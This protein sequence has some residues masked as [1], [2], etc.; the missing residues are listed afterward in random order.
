MQVAES[1]ANP[2]A[3]PRGIRCKVCDHES[4]TAINSLLATATLSNR[5]TATQFGLTEAAI[6]RHKENHLPARIAR[7]AER[8]EAKEDD[9]FL[10]SIKFLMDESAQYVKD[11]HGAV[12]MQ[13]VT[14]K[15]PLLVDNNPVTIQALD[16]DGKPLFDAAGD[17]VRVPVMV[18]G[19]EYREFRDVGA[20]APAINAAKGVTEL[21]GNATGRLNQAPQSTGNVYLSVIMPRAIEPG[22]NQAPNQ[23]NQIGDVV[24]IKAIEE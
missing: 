11:A 15:Q 12:K 5:R 9:Q 1:K 23:A 7:A 6:R 14:V 8:K 20:M 16:D 2:Q 3:I 10:D 21:L 17:A 22:A 13:R 24:D 4:V 19:E 18:N